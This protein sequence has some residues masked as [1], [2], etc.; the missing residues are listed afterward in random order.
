MS[1][2]MQQRRGTSEQWTSV[3]PVLAE[4]ELG[5]ESDTNKIKMGDGVN[6]WNSLAYFVDEDA[7]A[8][9]LGDYV[10]VAL[11]GVADGVATLDET[12]KVPSTQLPDIDE[13]SQDAI[14]AALV[15]GTGI[16][17]DYNDGANTITLAVDTTTI[18]TQEY[19]NTAVSSVDLSSKQ[20][21]VAG[22]SSAEIGYLDG[23]TSSIQTQL[24]NKAASVHTH[25][26]SDVT[27]LQTS[28]DAKLNLSGGTMTGTLVLSGA[29]T[30]ANH[31]ATKAYADSIAEGLHIHPSCVAATATNI[32]ISTDLEPGDVVDGVTLV[33]GDRVLVKAQTNAAQNG[34]YVV[35]ASGTALRAA[36]FNEPQEVDGGDFVFVTGGT[37][38]DNTGWVQTTTNVV[39]VGTDPITFTQFSGTG[40]YV[41]GTGIEI[42]GNEIAV[43]TDTIATQS[44]VTTALG[45]IDLS[46]KQDVVAGVSS[47]EIGYLDGVTSAIQ[48][49]LDAKA[50]KLQTIDNKAANYTIVATD[51]GKIIRSTASAAITI[52]LAN[53]LSIGERVDFL[54]HGTGQ[55]TFSPSGVTL[56]SRDTA[57]KTAQQYSSA[58]VICVEAGVYHLI[59]DIA[60]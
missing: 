33:E 4:G 12:G 56:V 51:S 26:I 55:V 54:Q 52:T 57:R 13:I 21:V 24:D 20:D 9:S 53:V 17:K 3:N 40:T 45:T 14:D 35:Q 30:Q 41:A 47:T 44:Y 59:G 48:T 28:L 42:T 19:V 60:V 43:D 7:V 50:A 6:N 58:T 39:T 32:S 27:D 29:P 23:V 10:E 31:A 37:L 22:V 36:D 1:T 46:S 2:R 34:I 16:T 15:A 8:G 11:L 49:Q 38:Y 18:A 25:A 5:W